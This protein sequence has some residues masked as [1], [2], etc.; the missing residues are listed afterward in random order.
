M[1]TK[2]IKGFFAPRSIAVVGATQREGAVGA[3]LCRNLLS[4]GYDGEVFFVN[5][6]HA[7]IFDRSC[8]PTV[9]D[10]GKKIDLVIVVVP[11]SAVMAIVIHAASVA[12]N[13][14]VISAGFGE[15][16]E[17]GKM[18]EQELSRIAL[19]K[20]LT[21]LG[22]NCLG[23]LVP[24]LSLNAS[25]AGGMP[26]EGSVAL[27]SQSGALA[28]ALLDRAVRE[29]IGFSRVVSIGNKMDIDESVLLNDLAED[30]RTKVIALYLEGI[31]DGAA[32]LAAAKKIMRKK[33]VIVL[34]AGVSDVAR[35][36]IALHTGA[37][38]GAD[39]VMSVAFEKAGIMRVATIEEFFTLIKICD[40]LPKRFLLQKKDRI[41]IAVITNAGGPGVLTVDRC[42][43]GAVA[44]AHLSEKTKRALRTVLPTA[45]SVENPVD[46]LGDADAQ[47][48]R[49][50]IRI[51]MED[52]AVDALLVL[53]TPQEQTPVE[54]IARIIVDAAQ[55]DEKP[56]ITSFI[57][58][59]RVRSAVTRFASARIPS[60]PFP[61]RAI[62]ALHHIVRQTFPSR[63]RRVARNGERQNDVGRIF[64]RVISEGRTALYYE[65]IRSVCTAYGFPLLQSWEVH[66]GDI[67]RDVSYPCVAKIDSARILHKTDVE[68]VILPLHT[69]VEL[70]KAIMTLTRRFPGERIIV[71]PFLPREMEIILGI[72]RDPVFGPV[73]LMGI[74]GIYTEALNRKQLFLPP[75]SPSAITNE[76]LRGSLGFLFRTTRGRVAIDA[77]KMGALVHALLL[78]ADENPI[79]QSLDVNPLLV[80][81]AGADVVAADLKIL[82]KNS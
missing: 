4:Y 13:F 21:I 34:K 51:V 49:D 66:G 6:R 41:S 65:E 28:V 1:K 56:I 55:T 3:I 27:L 77:E 81:N 58:G 23:F 39:D 17:E 76:I 43:E 72:H 62:D 60:V 67:P 2:T 64:A 8:Y 5:P 71:Q 37:L 47:R 16:D 29:R 19:E 50:V 69:P 31:A 38:A 18:R 42:R 45:A 12:K 14:V 73:A 82:L 40:V 59:E 44:I 79:V 9:K 10:I 74:G 35:K 63:D 70:A 22:P 54:E 78:L 26:L 46:V 57:G 48:Y 61:E 80:Y 32:F 52:A 36:A 75:L 7:T 25:F 15:S 24:A 20:G 68:G 30:D 11:S 53:L 33:P